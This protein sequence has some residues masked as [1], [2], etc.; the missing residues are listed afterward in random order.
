MVGKGAK[1]VYWS[2]F[3]LGHVL[4]L[5]D[6][7]KHLALNRYLYVTDLPH[8]VRT[9]EGYTFHV[10]KVHLHDGEA[11]IGRGEIFILNVLRNRS[12]SLLLINS[13][14]N[15][16]ILHFRAC[17]FFVYIAEIAEVYR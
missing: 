8:H 1:I 2:S 12:S 17:Y 3:G 6:L 14:I 13:T 10:N 7:F 9:V 16:I 4:D 11:V 5:G 15:A